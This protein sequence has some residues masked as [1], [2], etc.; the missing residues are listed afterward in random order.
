VVG[1]FT[2]VRHQRKETAAEHALS[3][4]PPY[5]NPVDP[6]WLDAVGSLA[7]DVDRITRR[8]VWNAQLAANQ[9]VKEQS[10][11]GLEYREKALAGMRALEQ[12]VR[13]WV[14]EHPEDSDE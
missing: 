7:R 10:P 14:S 11:E 6:D 2:T 8:M 4:P 13:T 9:K 1:E 12:A 5:W 3:V